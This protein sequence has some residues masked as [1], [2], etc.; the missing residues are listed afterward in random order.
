MGSQA[1]RWAI[2]GLALLLLCGAPSGSALAGAPDEAERQA[3]FAR[4]ELR[5]GRY[6][7]ALKSAESALRLDP[8]R[9]EALVLKALAYEGLGDLDLA[10]SL[11]LAYGEVSGVAELPEDVASALQRIEAALLGRRQERTER[12][13]GRVTIGGQQETPPVEAA[14]LELDPGP[15]RERSQLAL[16]G[17]QCSAALAAAVE[18]SRAAP[19]EPDGHRLLGDAHRC[20]QAH[21]PAAL[22]YRR[23]LE[24]GGS[25]PNVADL[26]DQIQGSLATLD[27]SLVVQDPDVVPLVQIELDGERIDPTR[28]DRATA[29][30]DDLGTGRPATVVVAGRGLLAEV[31][32]LEPL[33]SGETRS[34]EVAP[35]VVGLGTVAL[36][37]FDPKTT[38]VTV[39]TADEAVALQPGGERVVTAG[40]L[41]IGVQT[42]VGAVR[43][44]LHVE[45][46]G[47]AEL[48]PSRHLPAGLTLAGLPAGAE[49]LIFVENPSGAAVERTLLIPPERGRIDVV[50]GLRLVPE[51]QVDSLFG[52]RG[53]VF[54]S[55]PQLGERNLEVVLENGAWTGVQFDA[56]GMPGAA[57]IGQAWE[58]WR[59]GGQAQA[60]ELRG[61]SRALAV[62]SGVLL[63]GGAA[64]L[65]LAQYAANRRIEPEL[66]CKTWSAHDGAY[67]GAACAEALAVRRQHEELLGVGSA[68][69]GV[70]LAGVSVSVVF[71]VKAKRTGDGTG[72][73]DPWAAEGASDDQPAE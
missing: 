39:Y 52:G 35:A 47:R 20:M 55:H 51:T 43:I 59:R 31:V 24:L 70:G 46:G 34:V 61:A 22:A 26:L 1:T 27:V 50:S 64:A 32:E 12:R 23:Y 19:S 68:A 49:V 16:R 66:L 73:W 7:R 67:D 65:G 21:R 9:Y 38:T 11:L 30:F 42:A 17:G 69:I 3:D 29:R 15:Y 13:Q 58:T 56:A 71:G 37:S 5:E 44:P 18:L 25:D 63:G 54:V 48:E 4:D 72:A 41:E 60:T 8:S 53:G 57:P 2:A 6:D 36:G 10:R 14:P 33:R 28:R 62:V 40:D 45:A